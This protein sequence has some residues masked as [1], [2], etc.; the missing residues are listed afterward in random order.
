M[1]DCKHIFIFKGVRVQSIYL[2]YT[3]LQNISKNESNKIDVF[4]SKFSP[5]AS[6]FFDSLFNILL[7]YT[8]LQNISM[9]ESNKIDVFGSEFCLKT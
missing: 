3:P 8:P 2:A 7:A 9:H 4:G 5:N 6:T 1:N